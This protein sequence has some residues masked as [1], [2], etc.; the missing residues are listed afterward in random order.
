[1]NTEKTGNMNTFYRGAP[2][3]NNIIY[4][5]LEYTP[6]GELWVEEV[7]AG[8]EKTPFRFTGKRLDEETGLYYYGARYLDPQTSR[9]LSTDPAM[10]EYIPQA[11]VDDEARKRNG[12]LP[13]MGGVF[14]YVNLHTYHYAG[15]NPVKYVDPDGRK[16][17]Y[18]RNTDGLPGGVGHAGMFTQT[19]DGIFVFYEVTRIDDALKITK[20]DP[21]VITP[22]KNSD[23][24][25]FPINVFNNDEIGVVRRTFADEKEMYEFFK[26]AGFDDYIEFDTSRKQEDAILSTAERKGQ[27]FSNYGIPGNHCGIYAEK[28]LDADGKGIKTLAGIRKILSGLRPP[29][30]YVFE[31]P[32]VIG[33]DLRE[34]N[35]GKLIV[36]E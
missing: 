22:I 35:K 31:A 11:P 21:M 2:P 20:G 12:N 10:G 1:M 6:Y 23:T 4:E 16:S 29:W 3:H 28:A 26:A 7:R 34:I 27:N 13:G 14:N 24:G 30:T 5:H 8:G 33:Q 17:G 18:V 19:K 25:S 15:N 36:I 32:N 9:W